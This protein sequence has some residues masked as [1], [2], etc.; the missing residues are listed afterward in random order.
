MD[1]DLRHNAAT[2]GTGRRVPMY[3]LEERHLGTGAVLVLAS[4]QRDLA[5]LLKVFGSLVGEQADRP[6]GR[7]RQW[8][9]P[10]RLLVVSDGQWSPDIAPVVSDQASRAAQAV[11]ASLLP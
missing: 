3:R 4:G 9:T 8:D 7:Y 1:L 6:N 2:G 11:G 10:C 5:A